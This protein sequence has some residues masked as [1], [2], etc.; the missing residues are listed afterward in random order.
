LH[1]VFLSK[2]FFFSQFFTT[3]A[4]YTCGFA[5]PDEF[6]GELTYSLFETKQG[7]TIT[8]RYAKNILRLAQHC[9]LK[10]VPYIY[11]G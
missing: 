1:L 3:F 10:F 8:V 11:T 7:Q 9:L 6:C 2:P 4:G 5:M